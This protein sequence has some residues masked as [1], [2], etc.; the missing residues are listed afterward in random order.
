[1]VSGKVEQWGWEGQVAEG[2]RA[3][4]AAGYSNGLLNKHWLPK[5]VLKA[6]QEVVHL[7]GL[8]NSTHFKLLLLIELKSDAHTKRLAN[9]LQLARLLQVHQLLL[10]VLPGP[11]HPVCTPSNFVQRGVSWQVMQRFMF[12]VSL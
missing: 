11:Q 1:M 7:D 6:A 8:A 5:L 2:H 10:S 4:N 12:E 9:A 3:Q